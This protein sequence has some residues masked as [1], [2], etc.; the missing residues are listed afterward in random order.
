MKASN[1]PSL[2]P[3]EENPSKLL[4]EEERHCLIDSKI[5]VNNE[6]ND[7]LSSKQIDLKNRY[8]E[9]IAEYQRLPLR[10]ETTCNKMKEASLTNSL[11]ELE[12]EIDFLEKHQQIFIVDHYSKIPN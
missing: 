1:Q 9:V 5:L 2:C 6:I 12:H 3:S 11:I 8:E 4:S 10:I 7:V